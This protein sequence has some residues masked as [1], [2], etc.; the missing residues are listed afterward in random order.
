MDEECNSSGC[1]TDLL[2]GKGA[3]MTGNGDS[4]L[5]ESHSMDS[6]THS[7]RCATASLAGRTA[8]MAGE[9]DSLRCKSH[10]MDG[11]LKQLQRKVLQT[12]GKTLQTSCK[13]SQT[14]RK[15]MQ[16]PKIGEKR[17]C[18]CRRTTLAS[19][20]Y[21]VLPARTHGG[22]VRLCDKAFNHIDLSVDRISGPRL[23]CYD[24]LIN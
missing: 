19:A 20:L 21:Y 15:I 23:N 22:L 9:G 1:R 8:S 2:T 24:A 3:S 11:Y 5:C 7:M 12:D 4:L 17:D 16:L 10:S 13:V 14:H 18:L 6:K